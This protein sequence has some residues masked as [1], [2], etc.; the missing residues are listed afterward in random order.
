[1]NY[2]LKEEEE[3]RIAEEEARQAAE[4]E[5][6]RRIEEGEEVAEGRQGVWRL[7]GQ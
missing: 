3:R 1:M 5:R 7:Q 4:E 6:R 2:R